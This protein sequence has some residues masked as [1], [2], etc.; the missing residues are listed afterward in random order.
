MVTR[1]NIAL[2]TAIVFA[3]VGVSAAI[4]ALR[5]LNP[6]P[7]RSGL[8]AVADRRPAAVTYPALGGGVVS[9]ADF[10]GRVVLVNYFATWCAP[11]RDELPDLEKIAA[12]E[13]P[14]GLA[15]LAIS[16]DK[17]ATDRQATV[18]A[19]AGE[20]DMGFPIL[21][22]PAEAPLFRDGMSV[23]QTVLI[24]KSGRAAYHITGRFD[25]A[26]LRARIQE[27]LAE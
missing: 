18:A 7:P 2:G 6:P 10:A 15:V 22:P 8:L 9:T 3:I 5:F 13:A 23:P 1:S 27:L 24:D 17:P 14:R 20:Q 11:C 12:D 16:A 21:L 26:D 25:T 19:F 4:A